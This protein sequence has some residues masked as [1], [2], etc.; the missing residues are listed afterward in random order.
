MIVEVIFLGLGALFLLLLLPLG[1]YAGEGWAKGLASLLVQ[2]NTLAYQLGEAVLG[3]G[4]LFLCAQ[5]LRTGLIPRWLAIS[6]LVGYACLMAGQIAELFGIQIGTYSVIP[7]F[8]FELALPL[9]L[10]LKGFQAEAYG[11]RSVATGLP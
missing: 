3:F 6:G 7:G 1:Q 5:L 9:W 2:S 8:F 4:A 10:F 11:R